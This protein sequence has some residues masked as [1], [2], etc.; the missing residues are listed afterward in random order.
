M[1]K[2]TQVA[3]IVVTRDRPELLVE[4]IAALQQQSLPLGDIII[5]DNASAEATQL[6]LNNYFGQI[7]VLR[8]DINT[9]G[10]G[11]FYHGLVHALTSA[12]LQYFWLMDDDAIPDVD[13]IKNLIEASVTI[14]NKKPIGALC[15]TVI[16]FGEIAP[17]HRRFFNP[18]NLTEK[19]IPISDYKKHHIEIDTGSFVSFLVSRDAIDKSGL[20]NIDFFLAYDDT[21][22]SLRLKS[23]G[24]SLWLIP[25]SII[26]HKR[27]STGRL[28]SSEYGFKH[29]FNLRNQIIVFNK[30]GRASYFSY[31]KP[32]LLSL[33]LAIFNG[34]KKIESIRLWFKAVKNGFSENYDNDV[35]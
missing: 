2:S 13:A 8:F 34:N 24:F 22:Y 15:S 11:G 12:N 4:V 32:I 1:I 14:D 35:F 23:H 3:A 9:G 19:I 16:E 10:T 25:S 27:P 31:A 17:L 5:V 30:Y 7:K 20:P 33:L 6:V 28:R 26:Q 29:Y 18:N 21:E